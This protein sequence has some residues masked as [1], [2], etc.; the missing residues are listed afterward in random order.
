MVFKASQTAL[1]GQKWP[2][3]HFFGHF[4]V[5]FVRFRNFS[6]IPIEIREKCRI[7]KS[8]SSFRSPDRLRTAPKILLS[9][10]ISPLYSV[11]I[12]KKSSWPKQNV[13]NSSQIIQWS[14]V[15]HITIHFRGSSPIQGP[16]EGSEAIFWP[17]NDRFWPP[18]PTRSNFFGSK[19]LL[20]VSH[21]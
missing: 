15:G 1:K 5:C 2:K 12:Q 16:R 4:W 8:C 7:R 20:N 17:K 18:L 14:S 11:Y 6:R 19:C 3:Y 21:E 13:S 10:P 9:W